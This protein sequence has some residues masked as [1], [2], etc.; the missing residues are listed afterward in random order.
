VGVAALLDEIGRE[1]RV[2]TEAVA[3]VL[4]VR[5]APELADTRLSVDVARLRHVFMNLL[6]N[7]SKY[8]PRGGRITLSA[9]PAEE[10]FIR[11][12]VRD[13]G[14]GIPDESVGRVFDRFYRAPNQEKSGAGLGLAI[15]REIVVAHGGSIACTS[16]PGRGAEFHFL[17]PR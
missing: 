4:M 12:S 3:Q 9:E 1:T 11:F 15:A 17:L 14:P 2:F 5:V 10:N 16:E 8:S 6:T 13:E 7:A